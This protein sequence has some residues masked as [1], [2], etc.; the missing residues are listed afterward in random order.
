MA[1]IL[2]KLREQL[3]TTGDTIAEALGGSG[4]IA[5][6]ISTVPVTAYVVSFDANTGSGTVAPMACAKGAT[7]TLPDGDD[8]TPPST[9]AFAGWATSADADAK[10]VITTYAA[11]EDTTLYA[12]W[13]DAEA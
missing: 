9:K 10:D 12:I 3:G 11:T 6:A 2:T 13:A 8:L 1:T 4:S 5:D 7:I